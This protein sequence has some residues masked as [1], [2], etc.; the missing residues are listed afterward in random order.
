MKLFSFQKEDE[1]IFVEAITEI[2]RKDTY[3]CAQRLLCHL[4]RLPA[5]TLSEEESAV[6]KTVQ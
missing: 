3:A 4:S 5:E 2:E 6:L 1:E